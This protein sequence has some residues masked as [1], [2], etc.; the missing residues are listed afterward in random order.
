MDNPAALKKGTVFATIPVL[1]FYLSPLF[2]S[3][4]YATRISVS[5][6]TLLMHLR[7]FYQEL[8]SHIAS[9]NERT[10]CFIDFF[11]DDTAVFKGKNSTCEER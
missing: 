8:I 4:R 1:L 9:P 2:I 5:I 7:L 11:P 3:I 10:V 6:V